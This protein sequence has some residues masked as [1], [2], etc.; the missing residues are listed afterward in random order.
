[1]FDSHAH[2][3]DEQYDPDRD[4]L[5]SEILAAGVTHVVNPGAD[6]ASSRAAV[7]LAG[8]WP[9]V[10]AAA[11]VHPHAASEWTD[12]TEAEIRRLLAHPKVVAVG[13]VGLDYHY[14]YSPR[15]KQNEVFLRQIELAVQ[16]SRP[17]IV[18]DREA[19]QDMLAALRSGGAH[20]CGGVMH[21]Y[22]GSVE[23]ARLLL[24]MNFCIGLGGPVTFKN[25]SKVLEVVRFVPADRLLIETDSPYMSPVPHRG[26]RNR[27]DWLME[28]M[29]TMAALRE[30]TVG[31]IE[32]ITTE[33]ALRLFRIGTGG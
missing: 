11:G 20:R 12:E 22:S 21:M 25:A 27:S 4:M 31:E 18:H 23:M 10:W 8:R 33:N 30:T 6:L 7:A 14:D 2:Y 1:M 16:V 15:E 19:H 28:V 24:D 5:L 32:R 29:R 26:K 17:L 9:H 13:E 3:D